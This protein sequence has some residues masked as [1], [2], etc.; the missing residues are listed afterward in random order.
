[1]LSGSKASSRGSNSRS[2]CNFGNG[3]A[4]KPKSCT[5]VPV[6]DALSLSPVQSDLSLAVVL[7]YL[8][9]RI[10]QSDNGDSLLHS[11]SLLFVSDMFILE[12]KSA[13]HSSIKLF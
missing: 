5:G 4:L 3:A 10:F 8:T 7:L 13:W 1:M 9:I 12:I 6:D 2:G 11:G